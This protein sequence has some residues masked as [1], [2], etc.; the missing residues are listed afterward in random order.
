MAGRPPGPESL[1][2]RDHEQGF[3]MPRG[4]VPKGRV[5]A[6]IVIALLLVGGYL[7]LFVFP[8]QQHFSFANASF[9]DPMFY[10][11]GP[12]TVITTAGTVVSFHWWASVAV[13]FYVGPC[14]YRAPN[15]GG[16]FLANGTG[17][18]GSLVSDG[19]AYAFGCFPAPAWG[20][21]EASVSG[22]YYGPLLTP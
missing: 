1:L 5:L 3:H 9:H 14:E 15:S 10:S 11:C 20:L 18:Y 13:E 2:L 17:G 6:V 19:G 7:V 4:P 12:A 22:T 8:F 16:S 21:C